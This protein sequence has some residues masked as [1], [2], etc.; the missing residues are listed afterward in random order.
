MNI[1]FLSLPFLYIKKK[2][3]YIRVALYLNRFVNLSMYLQIFSA[4]EYFWANLYTMYLN[5]LNSENKIILLS[6]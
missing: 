3:T 4:F 5:T 1:Y 6:G 2:Y